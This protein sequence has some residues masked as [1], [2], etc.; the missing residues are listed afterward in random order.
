M[1]GNPRLSGA[2]AINIF[3]LASAGANA[4]TITIGSD[5]FQLCTREDL[6]IT[7]GRILI[8]LTGGSTVHSQG[9]ITISGGLP[10]DTG[11]VTIGGKVYTFQTVLTDVDGHVLIGADE[12]ASAVNLA[13]AINR[14]DGNG[15]LYAEA[16]VKHTTVT[17]EADGGDVIITAVVGGVAGDLITL[18][19]SA[20]NVAKDSTTLGTETA[21]VDPTAEEVCDAVVDAINALPRSRVIEARKIS[22]NEF[23]LQGKNAGPLTIACTETLT[24]SNNAWAASAMY[25]GSRSGHRAM[26]IL[27]RVPTSVEVAVGNMHFELTFTP[28]KVLVFVIVTATPGVAVAWD[29]TVTIDGKHV[30]IDND[31]STDWSASHTLEVFFIE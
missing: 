27:S 22:A 20:T 2:K 16:T 31:G 13:A 29:G 23:I 17:A 26:S 30:T 7:A 5:V 4:Q 15:T 1:I 25:G 21:G 10:N 11:T 3:R 28:S 12:A 18:A 9:K 6:A 24:G 19:E 8:D 14:D